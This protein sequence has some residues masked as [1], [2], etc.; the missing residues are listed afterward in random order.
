MENQTG[1]HLLDMIQNIR[2]DRYGIIALHLE[3]K[4]IFMVQP[5][6]TVAYRV[7]CKK[8]Q[9][10]S[11]WC[12]DTLL[13][14]LTT[15][16]AKSLELSPY[17]SPFLEHAPW[18]FPKGKKRILKRNL[19][20]CIYETPC[21]GAMSKFKDKTSCDLSILLSEKKVFTN[22]IWEKETFLGLDGKSEFICH[23]KMI[24]F[25]DKKDLQHVNGA[26][27]AAGRWFTIPEARQVGVSEAKL[28]LM[29]T[30]LERSW[31]SKLETK[32]LKWHQKRIPQIQQM[33][34]KL[35]LQRTD[36]TTSTWLKENCSTF[37]EVDLSNLM[38][39]KVLKLEDL[40]DT[41]CLKLLSIK[42][43]LKFPI[44]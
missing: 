14:N 32:R 5:S 33:A 42:A 22:A 34:Q 37:W 21:S 26:G 6:Y 36:Q 8:K 31:R 44:E 2:H 29:V 40:I 12:T 27:I 11:L 38:D 9:N 1:D 15:Q 24:R 17:S 7:L 10:N 35:H 39:F 3:S 18:E 4:S 20:G 19:Y 16:E 30:A 13:K 23:Y 28:S 43:I 25:L 41:R